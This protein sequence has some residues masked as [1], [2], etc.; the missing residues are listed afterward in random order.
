MS[1]AAGKGW[2]GE[3]ERDQRLPS[4]PGS[5]TTGKSAKLLLCRAPG[6]PPASVGTVLVAG[7]TQTGSAGGEMNVSLTACGPC[8]MQLS[9]SQHP[10]LQAR[11]PSAM[12]SASP[13]LDRAAV[14]GQEESGG[15][16]PRGDLSVK[17]VDLVD[18]RLKVTLGLL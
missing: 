10:K 7:L 18:C 2:N 15:L 4:K 13:Q 16:S 11:P 17:I 6:V 12:G 1:S 5:S 8:K 9:L 14:P 3:G